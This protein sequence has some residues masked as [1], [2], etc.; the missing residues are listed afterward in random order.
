MASKALAELVE[1][2]PGAED[3]EA[4]RAGEVEV[5]LGALD[6]GAFEQLLLVAALTAQGLDA[7]ITLKS[8]L[9]T[10]IHVK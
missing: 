2:E 6:V 1:A 5:V 4:P 3:G 8:T 10:L 9:L 7:K